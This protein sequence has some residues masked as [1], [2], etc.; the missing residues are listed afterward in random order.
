[1][2]RRHASNASDAVRITTAP[3]S[4]GDDI[5]ARQRRYLISMGIRTACFILAV[6]F[7][8]HWEMW[9][10]LVASLVLP[11]IAVVLANVGSNPDPEPADFQPDYRAIEDRPRHPVEGPDD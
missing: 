11:Y 2:R 9:V 7:V 10:F 8:G 6:V 3:R 5:R 4:H 1:M